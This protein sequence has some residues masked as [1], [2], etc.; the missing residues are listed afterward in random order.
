M[1]T[2]LLINVMIN[3]LDYLI[4]ENTNCLEHILSRDIISGFQ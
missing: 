4:E 2:Y 1:A 3:G